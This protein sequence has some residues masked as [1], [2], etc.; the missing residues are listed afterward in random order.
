MTDASRESA[1]RKSASRKSWPDAHIPD[2]SGRT[3][4]ITGANSGL[5][6]DTAKALAARGAQVVLACRNTDKADQVAAQIGPAATVRELD[7]AD[8]DSVRRFADSV[9]AADILINNAGIMA[10]P[11]RRTAQGF[12]SQMGTNHLGHFAL[13]ALLLPKISDRVVTLSSFMH[14]LGRIKLDDLNWERRIYR[15]WQAYG[16][17]KMANLMFGL[18]L[19][20]RLREA[21]SEKKSFI[22]HPGI[23]RT[24]LMGHSRSVYGPLMQVFVRPLGQSS[25]AGARPTLL[26]AITSDAPSGTFFGPKLGVRG[27]PA[28]AGHAG[29]ANREAGR[30]GLWE[31]S[32]K[33]TGIGFDVTG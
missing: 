12:E 27:G 2:Q 25:A 5:G 19:A 1:S 31:E 17:S 18:E 14:L 22:A 33:L 3:V 23:A 9:D 32:E 21:G 10:V 20:D 6:A 7:L 16:D 29:R 24:K 15:R 26:A 30:E 4:I 28:K 11:L 8:L 13:T